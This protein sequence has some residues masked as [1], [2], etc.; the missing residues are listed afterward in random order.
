MP[1]PLNLAAG[2]T[3]TLDSQT[4][5]RVGT[6]IEKGFNFV[7]CLPFIG[8]LSGALRASLGKIQA[9]AGLVLMGVGAV[10]TAVSEDSARVQARF[11]K[12]FRMGQE[13]T[14]HGALNV[15]RGLAEVFTCAAFFGIG[16]AIF[17]IPNLHQREAFAPCYFKYGAYT[18]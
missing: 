4:I 17:L 10:G 2:Y 5:N 11:N 13:H 3:P 6:R 15:I 9:V 14:L 7:G 1:A 8:I 18:R 12:I 16:N